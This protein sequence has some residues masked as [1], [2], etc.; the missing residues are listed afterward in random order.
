[1]NM[2]PRPSYATSL[3]TIGQ[4]LERRGLKAFDIRFEQDEYVAQCGYQ[5]PPA[6]MPVTIYYTFKDIEELDETGESKR[7]ERS[8]PKDFLNPA[9]ILRTIGG[10]LDRNEA[11]LVRLTNNGGA[12]TEQNFKL[13][14]ITRD[15]ERLVDTRTGSALYDMCVGMYKQRGRL[16][17]TGGWFSRRRR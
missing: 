6:P 2:P 11:R 14:Y 4:D 7:G 5:Q 16:T 1:M 8:A 17:G 9:Q 3:R 10:Y 13:E 12:G 15:G